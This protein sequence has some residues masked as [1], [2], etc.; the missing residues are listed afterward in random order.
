MTSRS[1]GGGGVTQCVTNSTDRLREC[2]TK[3][4]RG[5][6]NV[7]NLRDVIYGWSLRNQP[8][9]DPH[10]RM[11]VTPK[12]VTQQEEDGLLLLRRGRGGEAL[13]ARTIQLPGPADRAGEDEDAE[14]H[15]DGERERQQG[16]NSIDILRMS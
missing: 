7:K 12:K 11:S 16:C 10:D 14:D 1:R 6:K 13:G 5:S 8:R 4:G 15:D 9:S 2:G 3:G